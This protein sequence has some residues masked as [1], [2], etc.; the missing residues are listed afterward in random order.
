[1]EEIARVADVEYAYLTTTGRRTGRAHEVEIW[2]GYCDGVVYLLSGDPDAADWVRNL[3]VDPAVTLRI[4]KCQWTGRARFVENRAEDALARR[5]LTGKYQGW[6]D[7]QPMSEWG[8]TAL[9]VAVE[10]VAVDPHTAG[11]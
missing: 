5:L 2:F 7:G 8:R 9:P 1:M 4:G 6:S 11:G 10:P 3:R